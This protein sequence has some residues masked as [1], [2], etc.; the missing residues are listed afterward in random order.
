M[1]GCRF[2]GLLCAISLLALAASPRS[3]SA[4]AIIKTFHFSICV[5][6]EKHPDGCKNAHADAHLVVP[7]N[8]MEEL[9]AEIG[10]GASIMALPGSGGSAPSQS[11]HHRRPLQNEAAPQP[12]M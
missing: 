5:T 7:E 2:A 12:G 11:E 4:T 6:G 8:E 9:D 3:A 1:S 10:Q